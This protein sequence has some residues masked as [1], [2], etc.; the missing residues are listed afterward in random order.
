M[1]TTKNHERAV[2]CNRVVAAGFPSP[3]AAAAE[4]E[5]SLTQAADVL[6]KVK[7][8]AVK[9]LLGGE[10]R[11]TGNTRVFRNGAVASEIRCSVCQRTYWETGLPYAQCVDCR[12]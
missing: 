1:K 10:A 2:V 9:D 3:R 4:F 6:L 8:N 5:V 12:R 11:F 7:D